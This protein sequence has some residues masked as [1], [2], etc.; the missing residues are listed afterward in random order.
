LLEVRRLCFEVDVRPR[1]RSSFYPR[2]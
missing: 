1:I 2:W